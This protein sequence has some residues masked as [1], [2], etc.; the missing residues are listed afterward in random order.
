MIRM[1]GITWNHTRGY[2]PLAAT[3]QVY[4]DWHPDVEITWERRSL[5]AFGEQPLDELV[6]GYDLLVIDHPMIGWAA[7]TGALVPLDEHLPAPVMERLRAGAV[8]RSQESYHYEGHDYALAID[9]ACQVAVCRPDLL[10]A[11]GC[12]DVPRTWT[13]VLELAET[14]RKVGL[15]LNAIDVLSAFFTLCAQLGAPFGERTEPGGLGA[16][17]REAGTRAV[18]MLR[19]LAA[20]VG[21]DCLT[22]NPIALLRRMATTDEIAYC[23]LLYGYTNYSREGYAPRRLRFGDIP[24]FGRDGA[25]PSGSCLGGAGIAVSASSQHLASAVEFASWLA[26]PEIQRTEYLRA[27]GQPAACVAWDDPVANALTGD[28]FTNTRATIE[29]AYLRPRHPGFAEFQT[30]AAEMLRSAVLDT[31]PA[32]DVLDRIEAR[33]LKP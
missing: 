5:W 25:V 11:L 16:A 9:A 3:S 24:T 15:P 6:K 32:A 29:A 30:E 18:G 2:A 17:F 27:G 4:A 12:A 1:R 28:F 22:A 7:Q 19:E 10:T 23:P 13:E 20:L 14:T 26:D 21:E 31:T 8:G 33:Y